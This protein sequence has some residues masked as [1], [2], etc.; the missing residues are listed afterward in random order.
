VLACAP[1]RPNVASPRT[2][3]EHLER[4]IAVPRSGRSTSTACT[5]PRTAVG[6]SSATRTWSAR[7]QADRRAVRPL[8]LVPDAD[9]DRSLA[10]DEKA[11]SPGKQRPISKHQHQQHNEARKAS[12]HANPS[13]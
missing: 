8:D 4:R 12:V 11:A 3:P 6:I 1:T 5:P 10:L 9:R 7:G 2:M 13:R